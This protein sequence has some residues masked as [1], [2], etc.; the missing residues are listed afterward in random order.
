MPHEKIKPSL[1]IL[2]L[3]AIFSLSGCGDPNSKAVGEHSATP[4]WPTTHSSKATAKTS[5]ES[6]FECHGEDLK[7]GISGVSCTKCHLGSSEAIHPT[8]WG[9]YAYARHSGYVTANGTT[10]CANAAC[11]GTSLQGVSESGPVCTSCHIGGTYAKHPAD[12]TVIKEGVL[13]NPRG[14]SAYAVAN[15][16]DSCKTTKCHGSDAKGVFLSGPSCYLCH[17][18]GP[19]GKHPAASINGNGHFNHVQYINT[20]GVASCSTNTCHGVGGVGT[21]LNGVEFGPTCL[22][23]TAKCH[24]SGGI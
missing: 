18:V 20:N 1:A 22:N 23:N 2:A 15:G 14:H 5:L 8:Q 4:D 3:V 11:H 17:P 16:S 12:W 13:K 9:S 19:V 7:G 6:C 10:S 24:G 21:K